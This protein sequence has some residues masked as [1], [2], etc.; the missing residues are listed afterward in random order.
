MPDIVNE[1]DIQATSHR[2]WSALTQPDEI[3]Q[4]WTNDLNASPEIGSVV[5][6]R[7]GGWG[8]FVIRFEIA[9]LDQDWRNC[10]RSRASHGRWTG[11]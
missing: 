2:V 10:D 9:E 7:F 8:D 1:F 11:D 6:F 4:W 5:E 3:G